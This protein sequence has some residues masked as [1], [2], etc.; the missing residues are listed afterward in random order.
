MKM[1]CLSQMVLSSG[2]LLLML[3]PG[4]TASPRDATIEQLRALENAWPGG[5]VRVSV[6]GGDGGPLRIGEK[7]A[8]QFDSGVMGYLT[9]VHVD[10][11]GTTTLLY[12]RSNVEEGRIEGG[13]PVR[14]PSANDGFTLEV[15][16]PIGRDVVYAIVTTTPIRR[17]ELGISSGD[18]VVSMEPHEAPAFVRKLKTVLDA[19][20]RGAVEIA[21]VVQ[22]IDGR[23]EVQ[24]RSADIVDFFGDRTRS[25][26]PPKLDLQIHFATD[27]AELGDE[28]RRNIDEFARALENPK[29]ADIRF[30]VAGHTD[31]RGSESH[32]IGLS[33]RR[34]ETVRRYLIE[35]GGIA[36]ARL[37]IE[38]HGEKSPLM[39]D[40]SEYAR[41]MN[42][43]VD[44]TPAR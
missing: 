22:Q 39:A 44:F 19:R 25:I 33:R 18:V 29:L 14:L 28:A 9:A 41:R 17:R 13:R 27:S 1:R 11:H 23:G 5:E 20:M 7:L 26:R 31:D 24:Y 42:R 32:N 8:Y 2:V 36:A 34:A 40:D 38:A 35:S 37:E 6:L 12:P 21:H 10:T 43:R 16:P 30:T 3:A 4:A 15:Q